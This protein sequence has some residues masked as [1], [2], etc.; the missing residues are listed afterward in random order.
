MSQRAKSI[1]R[2]LPLGPIAVG[3]WIG[4]ALHLLGVL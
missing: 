3:I 2:R 4:V 1:F